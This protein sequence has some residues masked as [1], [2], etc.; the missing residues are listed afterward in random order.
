LLR[1]KGAP[2]KGFGG[3]SSGPE[4]LCEGMEKISNILNKRDGQELRPID[5][6][7]IMNIIGMIVVAGNV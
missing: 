4:I 2:I 5:A 7:D 6:L 1:S 3:T